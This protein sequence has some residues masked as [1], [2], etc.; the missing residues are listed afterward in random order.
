MSTLPYIAIAYQASQTEQAIYQEALADLAELTYTAD[1]PPAEQVRALQQAEVVLS[2]GLPRDLV[3]EMKNV[4][5][6]QVLSAGVEHLP[7]DLLSPETLVAANVG[8]FAEPMAEHML[9]MA[10]ALAKRLVTAHQGM[11]NGNFNQP[12]PNL[13]LRGGTAAILGFGGIGQE[14]ARLLQPFAMKI[15]AINRTGKTDLPVDFIG[16][17]DDL[18]QVLRPANLVFITLP[19][20]RQTDGLIGAREL[21]WMREDAILINAAR[22]PIIQEAA[23]YQHLVA[24]PR[25]MAGLDVWWGEAFSEAA[26]K[27]SHP[28]FELP[29]LL[30]TPSRSAFGGDSFLVA[31]RRAA[32]NIRRYLQGEPP[33]GL[34]RREDYL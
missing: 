23:L 27:F 1:L 11:K 18:E 21:G 24:H 4:R 28:F 5:L 17:L 26:F 9:A 10:L 34:V 29:N 7:Y 2:W 14:V 3:A 30:G 6:W 12:G 8:A 16:T 19:H 25:F 13:M 20:T 31:A 15:Y 22:G 33:R 32:E